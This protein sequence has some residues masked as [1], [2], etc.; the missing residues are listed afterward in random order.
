MVQIYYTRFG[1]R[2]PEDRLAEYLSAIPEPF[3][4]QISRYRQWE[5]AHASLFGKLLLKQA[6]KE[7][8]E[9]RHTLSDI[10]FTEH[11]KP[12][13]P[14]GLSFSISH[15]GSY[16]ICAVSSRIMLGVDIEKIRDIQYSEFDRVFTPSELRQ[17]EQDPLPLHRFYDFWT[18]KESVIKADGRGM[19]MPLKRIAL[20]EDR[21]LVEEATTWYLQKVNLD[22][23]YGCHLATN[24]K[25]RAEDILLKA[26]QF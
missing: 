5:D 22:A 4:S 14:G 23:G 10:L 6:L 12:Y 2:L 16:C 24:Q 8:G 11:K 25:L 18:Q 3:T 13:L 7:A 1:S 17:I 9:G 19:H 15:S 26:V 20:Q 21:A